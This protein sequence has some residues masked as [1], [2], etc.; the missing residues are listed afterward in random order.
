M[1]GVNGKRI[2]EN[3]YAKTQEECE[4]KLT[5]LIQTIKAEIAEIKKQERNA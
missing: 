1:L 5:E 3:V 4:E 2:A